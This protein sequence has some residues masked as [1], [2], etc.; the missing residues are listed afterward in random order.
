MP[1]AARVASLLVS[2]AAISESLRRH[3]AQLSERRLL[4][5]QSPRFQRA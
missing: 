2:V 4:G 5:F 3:L 1:A